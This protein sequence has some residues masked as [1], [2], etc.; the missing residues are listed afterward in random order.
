MK[1]KMLLHD[2]VETC[3]LSCCNFQGV[4]VVEVGIDTNGRSSAC[5]IIIQAFS[6]LSE[7][8]DGPFNSRTS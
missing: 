3:T 8:E 2:M 4:D 6:E 1:W 7:T 5:T